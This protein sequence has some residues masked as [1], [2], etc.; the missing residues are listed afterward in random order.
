[1]GGGI[2]L[3]LAN[4]AKLNFAPKSMKIEMHMVAPKGKQKKRGAKK[5]VQAA[6]CQGGET[7]VA[8]Y[9]GSQL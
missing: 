4:V 7:V 9:Q 6:S 2:A 1:M 3:P 5:K 8:Q